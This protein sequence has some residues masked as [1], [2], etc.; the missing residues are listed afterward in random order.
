MSSI[1]RIQNF[2]DGQFVPSASYLES[3]NP[4]TGD[5]IAQIPDSSA[6]DAERAVLAAR[7]AFSG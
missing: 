7:R 4:S 3:F 2:I 1:Q 6:N 5:V